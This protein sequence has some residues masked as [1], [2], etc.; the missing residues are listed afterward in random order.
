M[1][2]LQGIFPALVTPYHSNGEIHEESLRKLVEY[3]IGLGVNGFYLCGSTAEAFLLSLEERKH[4]VEIVT[5]QVQKRC[6]LI[7]HVGCIN[8]DWSIELA[9]HAKQCGVDAI[10]SIPPFYY[11]FSSEELVYHYE[12]IVNAAEMP[13]IVYNYPAFSGV[14][15]TA[16]KIASLRKNRHIVGIKHTSN[17]LFQLESMKKADPTLIV[18]NG[19]DEIFLAGL[20]MGADGAIGSTFNFM[21]HKFLNMKKLMAKGQIEEAQALQGEAN[22]IIRVL[23]RCSSL[24]AHKHI[25]GLL[26][27]E[28]GVCRKPFLPL[29]AGQKRALNSVVE[30]YLLPTT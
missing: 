6:A 22:E 8:T 16:E 20:S 29:S 14:N 25:I 28:C 15:F 23:S 2:D 11:K 5:D 18:Y 19:Y 1:I 4:I 13:M 12:E 26:G 3:N 10:S 9:L 24:N 21:A 27:I 30:K 7:C 17:D